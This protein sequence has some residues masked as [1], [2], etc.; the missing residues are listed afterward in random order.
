MEPLSWISCGK[1]KSKPFGD[2]IYQPRWIPGWFLIGLT[3][4]QQILTVK[5]GV[6]SHSHSS[7]WSSRWSPLRLKRCTSTI[8]L[9]FDGIHKSI[10][11]TN[12]GWVNTNMALLEDLWGNHPNFQNLMVDQLP[13]SPRRC[14]MCPTPQMKISQVLVVLY[15]HV[16]KKIVHHKAIQDGAPSRARVQLPNISV[17]EFYG[18]W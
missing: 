9:L 16:H 7:H 5:P 11:A 12:Q 1:P 3:H 17:A 15:T 8:H 4:L 13:T 2:E 6:L 18:L 14:A 10:L